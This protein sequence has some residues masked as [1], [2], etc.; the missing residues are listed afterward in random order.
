[1]HEEVQFQNPWLVT[2]VINSTTM[3]VNNVVSKYVN[4]RCI[5]YLQGLHHRFCWSSPYLARHFFMEA[6]EIEDK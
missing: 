2:I 3:L 5:T 4:N 1:M 6:A